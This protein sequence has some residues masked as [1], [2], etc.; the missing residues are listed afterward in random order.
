MVLQQWDISRDAPYFG[1]E[2][3]GAKINSSMF[4]WMHQSAT[5][6]LSKISAIVKALILMNS[7]EKTAMLSFITLSVKISCISTAYSG[8]QCWKE[9]NTVK[10]TNVFA[11]GYV[12]VDGAK[13]SKSRG[14]FIQASTYL[15]HIDPECFA[16]LLCSEIKRS[17][18]KIL[19]SIWKILFNV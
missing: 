3:P 16:L 2:I 14:T 8:Q 1:F 4:G 18:Q 10:P 7:G 6:L 17:Y 11:H 9:A 15:N 12:T 13:M 5:W 19:I